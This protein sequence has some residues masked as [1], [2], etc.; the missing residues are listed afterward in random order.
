[1]LRLT[2]VVNYNFSYR[3]MGSGEWVGVGFVLNLSLTLDIRPINPPVREWGVVN[4][5]HQF[6]M[7][8]GTGARSEMIDC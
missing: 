1:M 8:I 4:F 5:S 2:F 6:M 3:S 7:L